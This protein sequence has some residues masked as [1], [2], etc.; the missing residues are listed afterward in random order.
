[1][2]RVVNAP[3]T[4][5]NDGKVIHAQYL[6]I[7]G[8]CI[9]LDHGM[10]VQSLDGHLSAFQVKEGD[11]VKK[12]QQIGVSGQTGMAGGDHLHFSMLVNGQFVNATEWWDP[13]W[14]EDRIMRKLREAGAP[15]Q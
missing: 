15:A 14:I 3:V 5:A 4:A 13:H 10:G 12:G 8:N 1:L 7:Y 6:G 2:A 11:E 9:I